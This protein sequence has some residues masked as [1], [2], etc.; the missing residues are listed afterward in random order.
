MLRPP[1]QRRE[2]KKVERVHHPLHC[3]F[4]KDYKEASQGE[5]TPQTQREDKPFCIPHRIHALSRDG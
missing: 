1:L 2:E 3:T 4:I 5:A